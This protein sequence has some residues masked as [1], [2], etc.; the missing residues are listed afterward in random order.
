MGESEQPE[1]L[2]VKWEAW[3]TQWRTKRI[4]KRAVRDRLFRLGQQVQALDKSIALNEERERTLKEVG[5]KTFTDAM[6]DL[7][8][9]RAAFQ[10][11]LDEVSALDAWLDRQD[12]W[13][14]RWGAV[15]VSLVALAVSIWGGRR[16]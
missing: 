6:K 2:E 14:T 10:K 15:V 4:V 1:Q 11:V 9:D 7:A 5:T 3:W 12:V 16:S 13:L 8:R